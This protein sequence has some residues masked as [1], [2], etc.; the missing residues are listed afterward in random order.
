MKVLEE[1]AEQKKWLNI[2]K[3][4]SS[5]SGCL[6]M[7]VGAV[8]VKDKEAIGF[9]FN[10]AS[11]KEPYCPREKLPSGQ[12]YFLCSTH[13]GQKHHSETMAINMSF[14]DMIGSIMYIYGHYIVCGECKEAMIYHGIKEVILK[15][16]D[17]SKAMKLGLVA[18]PFMGKP[19]MSIKK[20]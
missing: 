9:G 8:L 10:D 6:K 13:C 7:Q 20:Q 4:M 18:T 5:R 12:C 11:P 15:K 19:N 3:A 1:I 16:N 17:E 14:G 2:A